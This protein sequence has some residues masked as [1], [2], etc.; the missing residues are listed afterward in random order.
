MD[1]GHE[2]TARLVTISPDMREYSCLEMD[3]FMI[4]GS[5]QA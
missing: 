2:L 3:V 4:G 1:N 5:Q